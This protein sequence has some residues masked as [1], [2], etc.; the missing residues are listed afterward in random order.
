MDDNSK[1]AIIGLAVGLV[2]GLA[3]S[4]MYAPRSGVKT[5]NKLV[6][7]AKWFLLTPQERYTYLWERTRQVAPRPSGSA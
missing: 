6:G 7:K 2:T 5:R 1:I 3:L 4:I